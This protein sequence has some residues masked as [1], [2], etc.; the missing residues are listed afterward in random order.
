[1]DGSDLEQEQV[2]SKIDDGD[3]ALAF[4]KSDEE[5]SIGNRVFSDPDEWESARAEASNYA[6]LTAPR[7]ALEHASHDE[8]DKVIYGGPPIVPGEV[9][10]Y[11]DL[12]DSRS[13]PNANYG[14][15]P[16]GFS[17]DHYEAIDDIVNA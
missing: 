15:R 11:A 14:Q 8:N 17:G 13:D 4:M 9:Q 1:M 12:P 16:V 2:Q 10:H 7:P 5:V 6:D 3:A